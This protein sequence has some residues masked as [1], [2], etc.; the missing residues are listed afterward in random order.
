MKKSIVRV[1]ALVLMLT[2]VITSSAV[3]L[4]LQKNDKSDSVRRLQQALTQLGYYSGTVDGSFGSGTKAAVTAFQQANSLTV[5]GIA[6]SATIALLEKQTGIDIDGNSSSSSSTATGLF[7]GDYSKLQYTSSGSRVRVLQQALK[8]LGFTIS[9]VDGVFGQSTFEAVMAFQ[10]ATGLTVDGKAGKNTLVKLESYFDSNGNVTQPMITPKPTADLDNIAY[11]IPTRTLREGMGGQD[12]LYTQDRLAALGYLTGISD[13][14]YGAA[15]KAAVLA[16]QKKNGLSADGVLGTNTRK[17]LFSEGAIGAKETSQPDGVGE[18]KLTLGMKGDDVKSVQTKLIALGYL[19]GKADGVY[20]TATE[21]AIRRFQTRNGLTSDG[22]CGEDTVKALYSSAAIDAGSSVTPSPK[23]VDESAP[24]RILRPG[25]SGD[26]VK[27]VQSRLDKFGYYSGALDGI[28]G[29]ATVAAVQAFQARNGLTADGKVGANTVKILYSSN[30]I[31]A[32][33]SAATPTPTPTQSFGIVPTRTL[34][35]GSSGDDVK[36]VQSRLKALGYYTGTVDGNY[37][38]GTMA[39]VASFQLRNNLSAD[40]VA[41]KRTYKKLYS[42]D[43]LSAISTPTSTPTTGVTRP[44]RLLY[45]GCT[46]DD[47]KSVQ[48]R[49]KDL[50]YLTDKVDGKYGANTVAAMRAFQLRNGLTGSGNGDTATYTILYSVNAITAEG[51]QVDSTTPTVY[52][53]LK[54]GAT[55]DAV[56]RLQQALSN[57]RYTVTINGTY[58]ETTRAAVLAF[59]KRNGLAPDGIAGVNTQTKLYT[60]DCVTGDTALPDE[61]K[62]GGT[63][64]SG[65]SF[66]N[67]PAKSQI[68]L[69]MWYTEI[70]PTIKSGQTVLV[71][72]PRSGSSFRL[73]FYSL[74]RHADSE[75]LTA[76][77]TAIMKAAWG[78]KFSWDEKPVYVL[79]PSGTWVLAS[80]HCMPHLSGSIKDNDFDGHLC[81]HFPRT[82]EETAKLDPKNGVRHQKDIRKAWKALTG[83]DITW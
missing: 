26:D 29:A 47:V 57:L 81:V 61:N 54:V 31:A 45:S 67:G 78:G 66:G 71:Y 80:M 79:L 30:A 17:R 16:F 60:G 82:M 53:N 6:G 59:Q 33:P 5:D 14:Q 73:R 39:A 20:G 64:N 32:D 72:E 83:E 34:R 40:G 69:Q 62:N 76:Q 74:G 19:T 18:R 36:S 41:G 23:P 56:L 1:L 15:T 3:A 21:S 12:V 11:G 10:K 55:G 2:L 7:K 28:Y 75:P 50:G 9:K 48:Q 51:K 65:A 35:E 63:G 77:D 46:G 42:S 22:I 4:K 43:A 24:T 68:K 8:D 52:T 58:D 70:K 49:L 44:T 37:G 27:S 13:G 38:T 25:M